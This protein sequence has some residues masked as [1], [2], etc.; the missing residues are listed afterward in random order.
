MEHAYPDAP[1]PV[2]SHS[3]YHPAAQTPGIHHI[4]HSFRKKYYGVKVVSFFD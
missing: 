2:F 3:F 4:T 1:Q